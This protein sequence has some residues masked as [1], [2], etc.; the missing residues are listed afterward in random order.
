MK[1]NINK[2]KFRYGSYS[3]IIIAVF[4]AAVI[5]INL[6][7][8]TLPVSA[9]L[10]PNKLYSVSDRTKEVLDGLDQDITIYVFFDEIAF[11]ESYTQLEKLMSDYAKNRYITIKYIDAYKNPGEVRKLDPDNFYKLQPSNFLFVMGDK[12]RKV[13]T[14]DFTTTRTN[15]F[16]GQTYEENA[17]EET[18]T[19][20]LLYVTADKTPVIYFTEGHGEF[21]LSDFSTFNEYLKRNNFDVKTINT[22]TAEMIPDEADMLVF[23]SPE[24]DI[25]KE[26][27]I[28][29]ED[30][31]LKHEEKN[32]ALMLF[33]DSFEQGSDFTQINLLLER[34]NLR[35]NN[36]IVQE[37]NSAYFIPGNPFYIIP[38][39]NIGGYKVVTPYSRSI[40]ILQNQK[41]YIT[42]EAILTT[43]T[44]ASSTNVKTSEV[45]TGKKNIAVR[46]DYKGGYYPLRVFAMGNSV[47]LNDN[48][49]NNYDSNTQFILD[50]I[51]WALIQEGSSIYIPA[52]A[53]YDTTI[54]ITQ[55]QA[56]AVSLSLIIIIPLILF[57]IG[58]IIYVRR[59]N[60]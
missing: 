53:E 43:S 26:E 1:I 35:F 44:G 30:F 17:I 59:K 46:V 38:D 18:L 25:S 54:N 13:T 37:S 48:L 7:V 16:T 57:G 58:T 47:F 8:N 42:E 50:Q 21:S 39:Y 20:A 19:G 60:L 56:T 49:L 27:R 6:I 55:K 29:I 9:D 10:T 11:K 34:Y 51:R 3:I 5:G 22:L 40:E 24:T 31:Y 12:K 2:R 45:I 52:K 14:S 23:L 15:P 28:R 36:D 32:K 4:I 41:D 33:V